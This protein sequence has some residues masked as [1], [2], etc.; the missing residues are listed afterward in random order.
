[1]EDA[2]RLALEATKSAQKL[3]V[4][5]QRI[6]FQD[7]ASQLRW[8]VLPI[9][10]KEAL[11][12]KSTTHNFDIVSAPFSPLKFLE[13]D[14]IEA[15]DPPYDIKIGSLLSKSN[16]KVDQEYLKRLYPSAEGGAK[17]L[18]SRLYE[19]KNINM[20]QNMNG[21]QPNDKE[22]TYS[23]DSP[24]ISN[25]AL[26]E[27]GSCILPEGNRSI[28]EKIHPLVPKSKCRWHPPTKDIF[29]PFIEAVEEFGMIRD[30]DRVLICLSGGKDSLSLLHTLRQYQFY[31]AKQ[32]NNPIKFEI[33]ALTVDPQSSAYDPRPLIPYLAELGV[34][35]LYEE[36]AIMKQG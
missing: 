32:L 15:T 23:D 9:E 11:L 26:C 8:M 30:G 19:D 5:D 34:P 16:L 17:K 6:L 14:K 36:Q 1:M 10:A 25:K 27:D 4:P 24:T 28:T 29:K 21:M 33:G 7:Q 12:S 31:A 20:R 2:K 35:Y 13:I 3:Q 18:K 22:N